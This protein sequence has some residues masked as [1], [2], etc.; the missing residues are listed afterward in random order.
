MKV[1]ELKI[2]EEDDLSGIQ[3]IS[4]VKE[5]ATQIAWEVFN[6]QEE[7]ISC[8][9]REDLPQEAIDLLDN[10]G[11][12]V[13]PEAF[14][15]ATI[16]DIDELVIENFAVPT[17][18]PDPKRQSIW[19]DNSNNASVITRYIYVVDTG[20]GAPLKPLSRQLCRKMLL[21]QKVWSK[22]DMAAYSLQLS[23]QCAHLE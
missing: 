2:D 15:N 8:S 14:F 5:P 17:I 20:V 9:H 12:L 21:S 19:D 3:Y 10:Y 1:F 22:D 6:N 4:I 7:P 23:S 11:T 18:N 16:K 13:S